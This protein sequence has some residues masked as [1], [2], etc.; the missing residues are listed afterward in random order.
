MHSQGWRKKN[1][2]FMKKWTCQSLKC[3]SSAF[4]VDSGPSSVQAIIVICGPV[5]VTLE[6]G[7]VIP[8]KVFLIC[9]HK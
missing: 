3:L 1:Y 6:S 4:E 2:V 7:W 8:E 9:W 5:S